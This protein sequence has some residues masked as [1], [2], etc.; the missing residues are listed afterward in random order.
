[1]PAS[2]LRV[3]EARNSG[4]RFSMVMYRKPPFQAELIFW[5]PMKIVPAHCHPN[6]EGMGIH[7]NGDMSMIVA[8]SEQETNELLRRSKV[9]PAKH[10]HGRRLVAKP[11]EWHGGK[12]GVT[13]CSFWSLQRWVNGVTPTAASRD[14]VGPEIATPELTTIPCV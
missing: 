7:I 5:N 8:E 11:G 2:A 10:L 6:F 9:W 3:V 12:T 4:D 13:G 1:M 14:W